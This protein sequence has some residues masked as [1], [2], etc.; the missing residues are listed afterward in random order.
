VRTILKRLGIMAL[1]G[2]TIG[3]WL[4]VASASVQGERIL[5]SGPKTL[6]LGA[7]L[8]CLVALLLTE[9]ANWGKGL[10]ASTRR[11]IVVAE[12]EVVQRQ[13]PEH[14]YE[15][16]PLQQRSGIAHGETELVK[17]D[18]AGTREWFDVRRKDVAEVLRA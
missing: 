7:S 2:L 12:L 17:V 13:V 8:A 1:A 3:L 10:M 9:L 11:E 4:D 6:V 5:S 14:A 16:S 18:K 15:Q